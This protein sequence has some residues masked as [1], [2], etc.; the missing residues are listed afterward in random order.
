[1]SFQWWRQWVGRSIDPLHVIYSSYNNPNCNRCTLSLPVFRRQHSNAPFTS[2]CFSS[3]PW[4]TIGRR[5]RQTILSHWTLA[6]ASSQTETLHFFILLSNTYG[7]SSFKSLALVCYANY[8]EI[9]FRP[10]CS[11][12]KASPARWRPSGRSESQFQKI[13]GPQK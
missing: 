6:R 2:S 4:A 8:R 5:S 10:E 1:M 11:R 13:S 7:T 9:N 3:Y 12:S